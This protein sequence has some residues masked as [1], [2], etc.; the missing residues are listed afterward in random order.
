MIRQL[1]SV[2]VSVVCVVACS[3][4]PGAIVPVQFEAPPT[5]TPDVPNP[6][7]VPTPT[8][9][10]TPPPGDTLKG[11]VVAT[12]KVEGIDGDVERFQVWVTNPQTINDLLDM[13]QGVGAGRFPGG[14]IHEGAGKANHN[15]PYSWHLD[16]DDI[17]LADVAFEVCDGRPSFVED[18]LD[19]Y[20]SLGRYCPWAAKLESVVDHR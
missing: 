5:G 17:H 10:P 18:N 19:V 12:F 13:E 8:P 16:P 9:T 11:G 4:S 2:A 3:Q 20:L 7:P 15:A 14:A 6:F 1:L